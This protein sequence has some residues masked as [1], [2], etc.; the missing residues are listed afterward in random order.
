MW[1][2]PPSQAVPATTNF[3]C[4]RSK[5]QPATV[6]KTKKGDVPI[7]IWNSEILKDSGYDREL[8]CQQVSARFQSI[9]RSGRL[10]YITAGTLNNRPV[11]CATIERGS[12]CNDAN[13][14]YTLKPNQNARLAI[15][16]LQNIRNLASNDPTAESGEIDSPSVKL[17]WLEDEN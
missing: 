16:R 7:I 6:A 10:K 8:R 9:Y 11:I 13:L 12:A 5:G 15:Q 17:D 3:V 2:A 1:L 4:G 14:L